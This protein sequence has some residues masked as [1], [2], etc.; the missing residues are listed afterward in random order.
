MIIGPG[1]TIGG[2]IFV[3]SNALTTSLVTSGMTLNLDA[4]NASSYPGSGDTWFD[5]SDY[6]ADV[7]LYNNPVFNTV[8]PKYLDF[9]GSSQYGVASKSGILSA[10]SYSKSA[11][12]F[13]RGYGTNNNIVSGSGGGHFMFGAAQ[14]KIFCGHSDWSNY[15]A[16]PSITTID[17]FTWYYATLTFD[18]T[19]GMS[20]YINGILD[21]TYDAVKTGLPGNGSIEI[22]SFAGSNLLYGALGKVHCYDRAL[23]ASE[24]L[25]NFNATKAEYGY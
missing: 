21:N 16:F 17:L 11:W 8:P 18:T 25:Q 1:I 6:E 4:G 23:S 10:T 24:V 9:N 13:W 22:A 14:N 20:L 15:I 7:T 19:N 2:G 5:L 3:D 12:F